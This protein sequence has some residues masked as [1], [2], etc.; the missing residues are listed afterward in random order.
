[1]HHFTFNCDPADPRRR[2]PPWTS[3]YQSTPPATPPTVSQALLSAAD[4]WYL[5]LESRRKSLSSTAGSAS[6]ET[7]SSPVGP[8]HGPH[9]FS[10][11]N[12]ARASQHPNFFTP[13][14]T[15]SSSTTPPNSHEDSPRLF[16]STPRYNAQ[17][18]GHPTHLAGAAMSPAAPAS[19]QVGGIFNTLPNVSMPTTPIPTYS[20]PI[21]DPLAGCFDPSFFSPQSLESPFFTREYH[22]PPQDCNTDALSP[23]PISLR[24]FASRPE[25]VQLFRETRIPEHMQLD[26]GVKHG[27]VHTCM[28][29]SRTA[30]LCRSKRSSSTEDSRKPN[31]ASI[32]FNSP[33]QT[34]SDYNSAPNLC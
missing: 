30:A 4:E 3:G 6:P 33:V 14:P 17:Q 15:N 7:I 31:F 16:W 12:A 26:E 2:A 8:P 24:A 32:H 9:N 25:T 1:M 20:N 5:L 13:S 23:F 29:R 34:A 11:T 28:I 18:V 21:I 27:R 10:A 22:Q 19:Q